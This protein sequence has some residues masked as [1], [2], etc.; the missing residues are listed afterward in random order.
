M[1]GNR[2][3]AAVPRAD[4]PKFAAFLGN[5]ERLLLVAWRQSLL[6]GND[7]YLQEVN[8]FFCGHIVLAVTNACASRHPLHVTRAY[9]RPIAKAVLMRKCAF[10][11]IG[12]DLHVVVGVRRKA[13]PGNHPILIDHTQRAEA[14]MIWIVMMAE[15]EAVLTVEPVEFRST[16]IFGFSNCHRHL[17]FLL[18]H[19][20]TKSPPGNYWRPIC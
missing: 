1:D 7:P 17:W 11:R 5:L 18:A 12:N 20:G 10:E 19:I 13:A 8:G 15:G 4:Q 3:V 2:A 6:L 14:H 16:S 9:H